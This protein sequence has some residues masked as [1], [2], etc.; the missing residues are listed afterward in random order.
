MAEKIKLETNIPLTCTFKYDNPKVWDN[1]KKLEDGTISKYKSYSY[2]VSV[3]K[4]EGYI[5][6]YERDVEI[7]N[8]HAPLKDK[9]L[10]LLKH[11]EGR[12]KIFTVST[13]TT[14]SLEQGMK[15]A[16]E[17]NGRVKMNDSMSGTMEEL[18]H[19]TEINPKGV[20]EAMVMDTIIEM[21]KKHKDLFGDNFS[22]VV[23]TVFMG[24]KK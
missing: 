3:G 18:A 19:P 12:K 5:S 11:E 9:T 22:S 13:P 14:V 4:I 10:V 16:Q 20:N 1:E 24:S 17:F 6:L 15:I 21:L 23:N 2:A 8:Q 7:L